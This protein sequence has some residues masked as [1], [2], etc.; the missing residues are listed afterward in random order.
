MRSIVSI[1]ASFP[2]L[3]VR[4]RG[5]KRALCGR[6]S[7]WIL[8]AHTLRRASLTDDGT[9]HGQHEQDLDDL[10]FE[11]VF[12]AL[13]SDRRSAH[14]AGA[15]SPAS[16]S[17][18]PATSTRAPARSATARTSVGRTPRWARRCA[19]PSRCRFR[20]QRRALRD[21]RRVH[22]RCRE[23]I[24]ELRA[25]D[26]GYGHRRRHRCRRRA[27]LGNRGAR[28]RSATIRSAR[29]T[30]SSAAAARSAASR[31]RPRARADPPRVCG[32]ALVSAQHAARRSAREAQ[33]E[34]DPQGG[35]SR[36]RSRACRV[37][38][39]YRRS[40]IGLA[41][42]VAFVNPE[43]IA[44]GG[45]VARAGDSSSTRCARWSTSYDDGPPARRRSSPPRSATTPA[46]SAPRPWRCAEA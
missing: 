29:P 28:A 42:I 6:Q 8:A 41:N 15:T 26:A 9:I 36:R 12:A 27:V 23:G 35:A 46:R 22:L 19:R 44:L 11:A 40:G 30:D 25:A 24:R 33:F 45:G 34:E 1:T 7:A 13:A 31:R 2:R 16:A 10:H 3:R 4:P 32:R 39:L 21:P 17:A 43:M 18:R 5:R 20:R 37:A 14:D 38:E